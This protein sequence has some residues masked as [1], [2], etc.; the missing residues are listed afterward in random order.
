LQVSDIGGRNRQ[1]ILAL[2]AGLLTLTSAVLLA[3]LTRSG[4]GT[5]GFEWL[6]SRS[7]SL[8]ARLSGFVPFGY[9]FVVGMAAA[10]NPCGFALLPGYLGLYLAGDAPDETRSTPR[11]LLAAIEVS[12]AVTAGFVLLFGAAGLFLGLVS[13][14]LASFFPLLGLATGL[15]LVFAG[16][17][18]LGGRVFHFG[19]AGRA[20]AV[21]GPHTRRRGV[22]AYFAYGV[23]YGLCSLGCT[24]PLFLAVVGSSMAARGAMSGIEQFVLYGLGMGF[25]IT[26]L[27]LATAVVGRGAVQRVRGVVRYTQ[28]ASAGLLLLV[29][30]Y[31]IYYWLT[32]GGLLRLL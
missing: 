6:S 27:T 26:L 23:A 19:L 7:T 2:L 10:V 18:M 8:I 12:L 24:L 9:A 17:A 25:V 31:V 32:L 14:T 20:G 29:G 11:G 22:R 1:E 30:G 4:G 16:S 21:V 28:P 15:L 13:Y 3:V 5:V